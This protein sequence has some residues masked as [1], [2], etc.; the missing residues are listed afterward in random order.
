VEAVR[1]CRIAELPNCRIGQAFLA[2]LGICSLF[3]GASFACVI[4][5]GPPVK[6][7]RD[8]N[9]S[10]SL[11]GNPISNADVTLQP[12]RAGRSFSVRTGR[13]GV[14]HF[15][16]VPA[17]KY[18][19]E[20]QRGGVAVS[21][22]IEVVSKGAA[23]NSLELTWPSL[24]PVESQSLAGTLMFL[25]A[26]SSESR[27]LNVV[28]P[29]HAPLKSARLSVVDGFNGREVWKG[30]TDS[31]GR[32]EPPAV[33]DGIYF[34]HI[35]EDRSQPLRAFFDLE[36]T[37]PVEVKKTAADS[38]LDL[39]LGMS[40]CGLGYSRA[41]HAQPIELDRVCGTVGDVEGAIIEAR[42]SL[43][44]VG[45]SVRKDIP[46]AA[47]GRFDV[48]DVPRGNYELSAYANG[49]IPLSVPI[50]VTNSG[51][52][53]SRPLHVRLEVLFPRHSACSTATLN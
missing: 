45:L 53:C 40:D 36:G 24:P 34:L 14:A 22:F 10:V 16:R 25:A 39:E 49:F 3:A 43:Y 37:V 5:Y 13:D 2:F 19:V 26:N 6:Y 7:S 32:F 12:N 38:R 8:F 31:E 41:C 28:Y 11:R 18:S 52:G 17:G 21:D 51:S 48:G 1:H 30:T 35:E 33:S 44:S 15:E 29:I 4:A 46:K 47:E 20:F 42:I 27:V 50:T 9:V 23:R